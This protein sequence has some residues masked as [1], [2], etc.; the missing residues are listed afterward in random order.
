MK[1]T[2]LFLVCIG[3]FI[4]FVGCGGKKTETDTVEEEIKVVEVE[5]VAVVTT[6]RANDGR[7]V[8]LIPFT[9]LFMRGQLEGVQVVGDEGIVSVRWIRTGNISDGSV[10]VL[11]GLG[12]GERVIAPYVM[13][14]REGAKVTVKQ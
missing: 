5:H 13:G 3:F 1:H 2:V 8:Y 9:A 6:G 11:S 10:E 12:E 7:P 14:L 4:L